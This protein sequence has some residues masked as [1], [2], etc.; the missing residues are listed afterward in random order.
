MPC[1]DRAIQ[2]AQ[3]LGLVLMWQELNAITGSPDLNNDGAFTIRDFFHASARV[4]TAPGEAY[5]QTIFGPITPESGLVVFLETSA[6]LVAWVARL[7]LTAFY[8]FMA[9]GWIPMIL[10]YQPPPDDE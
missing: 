2:Q 4:L 3:R 6:G 1:R 7:G 8:W 5:S 9:I 10:S